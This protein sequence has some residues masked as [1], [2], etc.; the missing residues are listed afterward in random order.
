MNKGKLNFPI[1]A[2]M[3]LA[4]SAIAGLGFLVKYVLLP[5]RESTIKYGRRVELAC[6]GRRQFPMVA[7]MSHLTTWIGPAFF[8]PH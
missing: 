5:G 3:F 8:P 6:L 1:D 4:M 7:L 2:L